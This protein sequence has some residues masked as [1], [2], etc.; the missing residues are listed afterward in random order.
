MKLLR[1]I[2][3]CNKSFRPIESGNVVTTT[4][5]IIFYNKNEDA[6]ENKRE[7]AHGNNQYETFPL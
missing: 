7:R 3:L 6:P 5:S 2:G 1:Q 4:S